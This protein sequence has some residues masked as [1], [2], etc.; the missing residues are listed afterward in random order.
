MI[1]F[2]LKENIRHAT[3]AT[4]LPM[5]SQ[6]EAQLETGTNARAAHATKEKKKM[7][8]N[9]R[10]S[11]R[12]ADTHTTQHNAQTKHTAAAT[13]ADVDDVAGVPAAAVSLCVCVLMVYRVVHILIE[14]AYEMLWDDRYRLRALPDRK[15]RAAG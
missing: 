9:Q 10:S 2:V 11:Q 6:S 8:K 14:S 5:L 15:H 1:N 3:S 13:M 12:Q 7:P 4:T